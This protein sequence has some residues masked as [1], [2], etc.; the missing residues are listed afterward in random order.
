MLGYLAHRCERLTNSGL[1]MR[2]S[3][4]LTAGHLHR[5]TKVW[6]DGRS[7][8]ERFYDVR[9]CLLVDEIGPARQHQLDQGEIA[10][11]AVIEWFKDEDDLEVAALA[12]RSPFLARREDS[13]P[14][15][16]AMQS[17]GA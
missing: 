17:S 8:E 10:A 4:L 1:Y 13:F 14:L 5:F 16:A 11:D 9:T 6:P 2:L 7:Y 3:D 12:E 15:R